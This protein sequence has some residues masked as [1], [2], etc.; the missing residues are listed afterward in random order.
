MAEEGVFDKVYGTVIRSTGSW[1]FVRLPDGK[2]MNCRLKGK[3][4]IKG[5]RA[6]NPVAVGDHVAVMADPKEPGEGSITEIAQRQ[7]YMIRKSINLSKESHI[8]AS[9]LDQAFLIATLVQPRTSTGFIDRFLVTAE[10]YHIPVSIVFN[11]IDIYTDE[12]QELHDALCALYRGIGYPCYE[13][14]ALTGQGVDKL[15]DDMK[16]KVTLFSGHSGV[17]KSALI[18][19][20]QPDLALRTGIISEAHQKGKHTTTFAEMFP[21]T[22][23][24]YIIDTPGIKEFGL[25]DFEKT[26][27][28]ERFPEMREL[29]NQCQFNNCTHSHEPRCAVIKAVNEGRISQSRYHNYISI[30]NDDY[31][32]ETEWK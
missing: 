20:L 17:G 13:V 11:K 1:Y 15:I 31:F 3:F 14:S 18:N 30:I 24:G 2:I 19:Q 25:V 12:L 9:N 4:R 16:D 8:I 32:E 29:M 10:A 6:T 7:N 28:A 23:G 22:F 5:L 21:L 27:V 26:E